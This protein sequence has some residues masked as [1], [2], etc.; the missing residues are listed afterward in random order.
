VYSAAISL[1]NALP[2]APQRLLVIFSG[3]AATIGALVI[4]LGR[5]QSFLFL[6]GSFFIPLFGVLAADFLAGE[7][8]RVAVRGSGLAAWLLGFAAYQWIQPT[9]PSWWTDLVDGL[10]RSGE[11]TGG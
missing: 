6:L 4:D 9:G 10:P 2:E 8:R 1:Q 3:G 5:Y 7:K 11:F